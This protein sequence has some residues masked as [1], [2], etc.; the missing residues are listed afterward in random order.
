MRTADEALGLLAA[1]GMHIHPDFV[2]IVREAQRR[3]RL[4]TNPEMFDE[5]GNYR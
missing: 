2:K 5:E 1:M 3:L 4:R